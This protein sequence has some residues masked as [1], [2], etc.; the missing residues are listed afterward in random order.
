VLHLGPDLDGGVAACG[1]GSLGEACG[2]V[3]QQLVAAGVQ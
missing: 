2:V 1:R 3:A